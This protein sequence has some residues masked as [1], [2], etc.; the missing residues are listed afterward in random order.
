LRFVDGGTISGTDYN[1]Q[2]TRIVWRGAIP[3]AWHSYCTPAVTA[4][5][6]R[7]IYDGN[8]HLMDTDYVFNRDFDFQTDDLA[9]IVAGTVAPDVQSVALHEF[10]HWGVLGHTSDTQAVMY[11]F[12]S[13]KR[14]LRQHDIDSMR[15]TYRGH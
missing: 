14:A 13:C 4:A 1:N 3:S 2:D 6:A 10:G 9:C 5:C 8:D 12:F 11:E 15:E 7:W